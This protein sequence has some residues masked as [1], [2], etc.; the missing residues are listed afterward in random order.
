MRAVP[1][2]DADNLTTGKPD[3]TLVSSNPNVVHMGND[4]HSM[5][6][7]RACRR[8]TGQY[9]VTKDSYNNS[10]IV[11]Y[12]LNATGVDRNRRQRY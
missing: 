8:S 12:P 10:S 7:L 4:V 11:V 6:G 9:E 2:V 5:H 3:T 1:N